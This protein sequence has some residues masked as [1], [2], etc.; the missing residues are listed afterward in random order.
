MKNIIVEVA[1]P[2]SFSLNSIF[3]YLVPGS[4]D[5]TIAI[6]SRVLVPFG[7]RKLVG[8]V[9]NI[10]KHS[11]FE[12]KLKSIVKILDM[13]P[14]LNTEL[15]SLGEFIEKKYFCSRAEGIHA[16]L[17][18]GVKLSRR[19]ILPD[20]KYE[21][22]KDLSMSPQESSFLKDNIL[23]NNT[24]LLQVLGNEEKWVAYSALI[25]KYLS[26]KKSVIFLVPDHEKIAPSVK[27]LRL[28]LIEPLVISSHLGRQS[29]QSW[30]KAKNSP[31]CMVVGTRSAVFSP[32]NNLGLIL[33]DEE[34][35]FAYRQDQVPHYRTKDIALERSRIHD[36]SLVLS[37]FTPSLEAFAEAKNNGWD[38]LK[39]GDL[40]NR[41]E[42]KLI[43]MAGERRYGS[44]KKIISGVLEHYIADVLEKKGRCLIFVNKKGFSTFLYCKKCKTTQSC[45][46]CS[47]SL[48]YHYK[49]K[50]AT[51]PKCSFKEPSPELCPNCKSSYIK[52]FGYGI[53]KAESE[54]LRLFPNAKTRIYQRNDN[55]KA[56]HDIMLCTQGM[57][58]S[59]AWNETKYET[60]AV[61]SCEDM[62]GAPDF[63]ATE[64][65]FG[66]LLKLYS[67][68]RNKFLIQTQVTENIALTCLQKNDIDGF[69]DRELNQR[70]ELDLPPSVKMGMVLVR[71]KDQIKAKSCAAVVYKSLARKKENNVLVIEPVASTPFKLRG[72]Y[73]Y[74]VL[75]KYKR[76]ESV[77]KKIR[78]AV[79][80]PKHGVIVTF[81][82]ET[83]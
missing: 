6:G 22:P 76:L 43:D 56:D 14:A 42:I 37:S 16:V 45:P 47:S 40:V 81:D 19:N 36:S 18:Q 44:N 80:K 60:V 72:N 5:K 31:Y 26:E 27:K 9:V 55:Y 15:L 23:K 57:L 2:I 7:P 63:R 70:S 49:D 62:L 77:E 34:D 24:V 74:H 32:V 79:E 25:K 4:M 59:P 13:D 78:A 46:R 33:I 35:H 11:P 75:V 21:P 53:E 73:R 17:P 58:E 67:I 48:V 3:D 41:P 54:L 68:A 38:Y 64:K 83:E 66:R 69:Y 8:Y 29:A 30:H 50:T 61:L 10:K 71:S 12:S 1:I 51:C 28:S 82:P 52:Y 65:T 39:V 20:L